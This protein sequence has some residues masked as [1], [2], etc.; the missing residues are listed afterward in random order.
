MNRFENREVDKLRPTELL[1]GVN[2]YA[3]GSCLIKCGY[4]HVLC[5]ATI[6][7]KVPAWLKG[8]KQGWI[9]AEYGM[10][11]RSTSVRMDRESIKGQSGRTQEIQRLIGRSLRSSIDL[12]ALDGFCI[13]V[14]CDVLQA[15]GG[16]RTASITGGFVALYLACQK[17]FNAGMINTFPITQ[18]VAAT[19][20]GIL[21]NEPIL[22]LNAEEDCKAETDANFVMTDKKTIIEIQGT[23]EH[24]PFSVNQLNTMLDLAA[25]GVGKLITLQ[26]NVLNKEGE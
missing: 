3:D 17:L 18:F 24:N 19:S 20:C 7:E 16:T 1:V 11:P 6:E 26:K 5:A 13:K 25:S 2:K 10:L 9:T 23:A 14:D 12:A 4:T 8:K 22:D 15:D 21:N